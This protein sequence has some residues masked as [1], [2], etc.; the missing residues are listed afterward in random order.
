MHPRFRISHGRGR[1]SIHR[2]EVP[3]SLHRRIAQRKRLRE[4][5][6]GVVDRLIAVRMVLTKDIPDDSSALLVRFVGTQTHLAHRVE[7]PAVHRLQSVANVRQGPAHDDRHGVIEITVLDF[8]LYR[9]GNDLPHSLFRFRIFHMPDTA[10]L[11]VE[12]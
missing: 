1:V 11:Y 6:Q 12:V 5:N 4:P 3:L 10:C 7:D 2:T 8:I 9:D